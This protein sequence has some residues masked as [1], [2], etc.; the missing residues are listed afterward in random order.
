M[1]LFR[2]TQYHTKGQ[3]FC[4]SLPTTLSET[5]HISHRN[6]LKNKKFDSFVKEAG[7]KK[8]YFVNLLSK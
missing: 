6:F 2:H 1:I 5:K 3:S 8:R 7:D 4:T